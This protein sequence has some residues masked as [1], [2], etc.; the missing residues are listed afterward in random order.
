MNP[1]LCSERMYDLVMRAKEMAAGI[2]DYISGFNNRLAMME[3][4]FDGEF[5]IDLNWSMN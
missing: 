4:C 1:F 5:A 2:L 3:F